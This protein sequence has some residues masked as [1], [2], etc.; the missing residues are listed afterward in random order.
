MTGSPAAIGGDEPSRARTMTF[1]PL[2]YASREPSD[3]HRGHGP[4]PLPATF[5]SM[6]GATIAPVCVTPTTRSDRPVGD[7]VPYASMVPS[8]EKAGQTFQVF[9]APLLATSL[10]LPPWQTRKI[11]SRGVGDA[12]SIAPGTS[13]LVTVR[14]RRVSDPF[15]VFSRVRWAGCGQCARLHSILDGT[16]SLGG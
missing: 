9:P 10:G 3:D 7:L 2:R 14:R 11:S 6:L 16:S 1:D 13:R 15:A 12:R 5:R 8:G 4:A